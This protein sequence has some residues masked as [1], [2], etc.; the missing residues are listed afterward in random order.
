MNKKNLGIA[1]AVLLVVCCLGGIGLNRAERNTEEAVLQNMQAFGI[2][3][4]AAKYSVI[5]KKLTLTNLDYN[6]STFGFPQ[7]GTIAVAEVI[8]FNPD[9]LNP[10][11]KTLPKV[12]D[13]IN[14]K[15]ISFN[16]QQFVPG[17]S[18]A[19]LQMNSTGTVSHV[20]ILG[21]YQNLGALAQAYQQGFSSEAF[22]TEVYRNRLGAI[23]YSDYL[24]TVDMPPAVSP[25]E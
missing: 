13:S 16:Y 3:C 23:S 6:L 2:N 5:S 18:A 22:W 24:I 17:N 11:E 25:I 15:G 21:W 8:G 14:L 7:Q 9:C 1:G 20:Q 12:A 10:R 19:E 4:E